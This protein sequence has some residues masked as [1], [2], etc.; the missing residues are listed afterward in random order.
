MRSRKWPICTDSF[1][2]YFRNNVITSYLDRGKLLE[3]FCLALTRAGYWVMLKRV[4]TTRLFRFLATAGILSV[5]ERRVSLYSHSL[6]SHMFCFM[7]SSP[8]LPLSYL[9]QSP[10]YLARR[11]QRHE[12]IKHV[13]H[14]FFW[15][16][17]IKWKLHETWRAQNYE[18]KD[19]N[20]KICRSP[21]DVYQ[22]KNSFSWWFTWVFM[23]VAYFIR[24]LS[25]YKFNY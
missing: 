22:T 18:I 10:G 24:I 13:G 19:V 15:I 25:R 5:L 8:V 11:N 23:V 6:S 9:H 7:Q 3:Y 1:N 2:R 20:G 14:S 16:K 4:K 21:V 17:E 12:N